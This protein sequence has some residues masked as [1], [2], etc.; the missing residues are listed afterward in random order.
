MRARS[1]CWP[2]ACVVLL[3]IASLSFT[4]V[5]VALQSEVRSLRKRLA[6]SEDTIE[7]YREVMV[8]AIKAE[9]RATSEL[10]LFKASVGE[11]FLPMAV[12]SGGGK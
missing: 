5:T 2:E 7:R 3:L 10:H 1:R 8:D 6:E 11:D 12:P 4:L 9:E